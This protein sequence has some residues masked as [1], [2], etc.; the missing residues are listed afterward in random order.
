VQ[1]ASFNVFDTI[2]GG[3]AMSR[4]AHGADISFFIGLPVAGVLY[5]F[6]CRSVDV[7]AETRVAEAEAAALEEAL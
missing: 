4:T 6:F 7:A 1:Y 5:Y 3:E 2:L